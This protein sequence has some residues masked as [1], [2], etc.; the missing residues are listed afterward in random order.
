MGAGVLKLA[1]SLLRLTAVRPK[2]MDSTVQVAFG[3]MNASGAITVP[4]LR[5]CGGAAEQH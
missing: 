4:R 2:A 3:L 5:V 1:T